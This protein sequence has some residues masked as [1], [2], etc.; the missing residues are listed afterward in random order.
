MVWIHFIATHRYP[1]CIFTSITFTRSNHRPDRNTTL[2][3]VRLT[4]S[5]HD[6]GFVTV[7]TPCIVRSL[8]SE[9]QKRSR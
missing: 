1:L 4:G 2:V 6:N 9:L 7:Y 8:I 5:L 3:R